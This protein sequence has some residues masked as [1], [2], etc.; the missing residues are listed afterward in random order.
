MESEILNA[1]GNALL[2]LL[3]PERMMFLMLG[4]VLG[5]I[6]AILPGIGAIAGLSLLLP[7]TFDM[8]PFSALA[9]MMGLHAVVAT[10]DLIPAVLF[11]VPGGVGSA[12]TVLDGFPLAKKGEAGRALGAG[13]SAS[14]LGGL[15]GALILGISVPI[16]RPLV[17]LFGSPEM[18][19]LCIF[20]LSLVAS[21][22][23]SSPLKGLA[24][25]C[26]GVLLSSVG[27]DPQ[28]G[29]LRW[30]F[31]S[32]YLW[33]GMPIA[34]V[35][36]A[37]FAVPELADVAISRTAIA[38]T[39]VYRA[40]AKSQWHGTVDVFRHWWLMIRC[41]T[42][43][44]SLGAMPGLGASVIDWI[45]YGHAVRTEKNPETFGSGDIRGVIAA[46]SSN[47]AKEG[48]SLVPTIAFGVPGTASMAL[49]LGAFLIQ[50]IVPGPDMLT[51]HLDITYSLVWS[52]ALANLIGGGICYL[53]ANQ[54]GKIAL[55]RYG[56]L[57]P[58][59][60]AVTFVGAYAGSSA[61]GDIFVTVGFGVLAWIMKR[62]GWPRPP[63]VLGFILGGMVERY[64]FIS[65]ERYGFSFLTNPIVIVM[66]LVTI[67]GL[68]MPIWR[69]YQR[70]RKAGRPKRMMKTPQFGPQAGMAT[71]FVAVFVY[72]IA[73]AS[74]W[75]F[76]AKLVPLTFAIF[77][78]VCATA[79][80]LVSIFMTPRMIAATDPKTGKTTFEPEAEIIVDL[81][82]D[83]GEMPQREI[84]RRFAVYI[85][86][87]LFFIAAGLVIG[88][89]PAMLVFMLLY[90]R[91]GGGERWKLVLMVGLPLF[92]VWYGVFHHVV[93]IP[94]PQSLLG[95]AFPILRTIDAI[96]L[97]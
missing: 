88:L 48:G 77:G 33:D 95:D 68:G 58:P 4:I 10:G 26:F 5:L 81:E 74:E 80:T 30:T 65:V 97:F 85:G 87:L 54:I 69:K 7:F 42:I 34:P 93:H 66:L 37:L 76:G 2:I 84:W 64:M 73:T 47:N 63:V 29:T 40:S 67:Y 96:N 17:M 25:A 49:L 27:D 22:S 59:V 43:G 9:V 19:A 6:V 55:V 16:M 39:E 71:F 38:G 94:W 56:L 52:V 46:E 24:G 62:F 28:T 18:L 12:A 21:L 53:F 91:Y 82:S 13:Y 70:E 14:I 41:S 15:F 1:A 78:L 23:G 90:M 92:A 79:Y 72:A 89:L 60:L 83:F 32:L 51:K 86:W 57:V 8:D 50:G 11:G 31:D 61:W 20:G 35:A 36:L 44:V 3:T 75:D 45:A